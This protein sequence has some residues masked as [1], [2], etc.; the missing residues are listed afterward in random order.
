MALDLDALTPVQGSGMSG[1]RATRTSGPNPFLDNGW[2][3]ASYESGQDYE[4]PPVQG[5]FGD[6]TIQRGDNAGQ[7]GQRWSGDVAAV[8]S[9][10]RTAAD[11]QNIGVS[12]EVVPAVDARGRER[13]GWFVVK[14]LGKERKV[15]KPRANR[16]EDEDYE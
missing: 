13:K 11:K 5:E 2:L 8:I 1:R 6:Y 9:M 14:Y 16:V 15:F 10:I 4:V 12:I 3:W 7:I